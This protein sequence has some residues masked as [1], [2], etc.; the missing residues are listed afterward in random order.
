MGRDDHQQAAPG[1]V[2]AAVLTI[3]DTRTP[4]TDTS[5]QYLRREIAALGHTLSGWAIVRD[6]ATEIR[7]AITRL[8]GGR[9]D[10]GPR[11]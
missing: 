9:H 7:P 5:G 2:R 8:M 11:C 10:E 4:D 6:D 3:S 1:N